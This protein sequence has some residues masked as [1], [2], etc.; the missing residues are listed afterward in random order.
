MSC[1]GITPLW[2]H[3]ISPCPRSCTHRDV[4]KSGASLYGVA[5]IELL[6]KDT[7]KFESR[8][9]WAHAGEWVGATLKAHSPGVSITRVG[10]LS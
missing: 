8:W 3:T 10:L 4:F 1:G 6:A 2:F 9:G 7:H 5:D